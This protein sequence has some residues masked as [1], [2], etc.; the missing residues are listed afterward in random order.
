MAQTKTNVG[1]DVVV[2]FGGRNSYS[3]LVGM[4]ISAAIM[5]SSIEVLQ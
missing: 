3:L 4:Q 1:E 5:E 2:V